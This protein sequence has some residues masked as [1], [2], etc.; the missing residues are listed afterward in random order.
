L[1]SLSA[2]ARRVIRACRASECSLLAR[3]S[4]TEGAA[5]EATSPFSAM[6]LKLLQDLRLTQLNPCSCVIN[7][8]YDATFRV[9]NCN[10]ED[11]II[12]LLCVEALKV[13]S[14]RARIVKEPS[15]TEAGSSESSFVAVTVVN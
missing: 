5:A 12:L 14:K 9:I 7:K 4:E 15:L 1:T 11:L 6:T 2:W 13:L 8:L 10:T 3:D